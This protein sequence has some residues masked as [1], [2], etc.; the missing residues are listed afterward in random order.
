[1]ISIDGDR[2]PRLGGL[3]VITAS[4]KMGEK[5]I[6]SLGVVGPNRMDYVRVVSVVEYIRHILSGMITRMSS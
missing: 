2:D 6:G 5:H 4:Y 3:S 1:V